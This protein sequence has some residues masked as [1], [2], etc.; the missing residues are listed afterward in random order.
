MKRRPPPRIYFIICLLLGVGFLLM[1]AAGYQVHS[2]VVGTP[3]FIPRTRLITR[4]E[5]L[6]CVPTLASMALMIWWRWRDNRRERRERDGQCL[7]CGYDLHA[8]PDRCPECGA[9]PQ[10][11]ATA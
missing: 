5:Y 6:A 7:S 8:T 2:A 1:C 4:L 9:V 3:G 10:A 11:K